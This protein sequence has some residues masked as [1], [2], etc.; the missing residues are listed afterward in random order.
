MASTGIEDSTIQTS[1]TE[2][3]TVKFVPAV[4]ISEFAIVTIPEVSVTISVSKKPAADHVP[5]LS[6]TIS[7]SM[8]TI[9]TT[10][11]EAHRQN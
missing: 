6:E 9:R 10:I 7:A 11:E 8:E 5:A 3:S 4:V 2:P 1:T